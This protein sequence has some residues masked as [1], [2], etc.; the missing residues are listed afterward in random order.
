MSYRSAFVHRLRKVANLHFPF[1]W[2]RVVRGVKVDLPP[3]FVVG[4]GHSGTSLTLAVLGSHS[5]IHPIG[6]ESELLLIGDRDRDEMEG[7]RRTFE[8]ETVVAGKRRWIEKTP[9]HIHFI[10]RIVEWFPQAKIL[11]VIRDGRD[12]ACSIRDRT[13]SLRQGIERWVKDNDAGKPFWD[14]PSVCVFRYEDLV[15]HPEATLR[16]LTTFLDERYEPRMLKYHT[17]PRRYYAKTIERPVN[18][19]GSNHNQY[20]NWQINQPIFNGSGRWR[21]LDADELAM[22]D[23]VGGELLRELGYTGTSHDDS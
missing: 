9:R 21:T 8:R 22:I 7:M 2:N 11:L 19:R 16:K 13:G 18:P 23:E 10:E 17:T 3:V 14:H 12:V 6:F 5:R 20:R 4:C 15:N 1:F